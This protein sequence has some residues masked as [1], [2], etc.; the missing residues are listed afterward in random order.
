[1]ADM[2]LLD[3]RMLERIERAVAGAAEQAQKQV[4]EAARWL[5]DDL[6][7]AAN[8]AHAVAGKTSNDLIREA[9]LAEVAEFT[10]DNRHDGN[11]EPA[12]IYAMNVSFESTRGSLSPFRGTA[13]WGGSYGGPDA[14]GPKLEPG[15][16]R[17]LVLILPVGR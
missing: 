1:M 13:S 6:R 16:Y 5:M 3:E 10:I 11:P 14:R 8:A 15:R 7:I 17:A 2:N 9:A 4:G 12:T